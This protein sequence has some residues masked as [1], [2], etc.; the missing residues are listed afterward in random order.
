MRRIFISLEIPEK[1]REQIT[2]I[3]KSRYLKDDLLWEPLD[4]MHLT[5]KYI[6]DVEEN[7]IEEV[8]EE[9]DRLK[10]LPAIKN[11]FTR[12]GN[13]QKNRIP[14]I[15]WVGMEATEE[16]KNLQKFIETSMGEIGITQELR[17]YLPHVTLIRI[18]T[19]VGPKFVGRFIQCELP[20]EH[21]LCTKVV[22]YQSKLQP[23]G[24]V[25][26]PLKTV[27]L[28]PLEDSTQEAETL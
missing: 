9:M 18:K 12:F 14:S 22:L 2:E 11:K 19:P 5:L 13:F 6:G 1:N 21:F 24:A 23:G 15:L 8:M 26:V 17:P 16:L 27:D 3:R 25:Y 28:K 20:D 7:V 4:K 10:E